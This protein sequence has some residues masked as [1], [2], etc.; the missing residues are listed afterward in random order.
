MFKIELSDTFIW[1]LPKMPLQIDT[2]SDS[3]FSKLSFKNFLG[4]KNSGQNE[5]IL[6][7]YHYHSFSLFS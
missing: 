6:C 2:S 1:N 3:S 7:L 5:E 4:L